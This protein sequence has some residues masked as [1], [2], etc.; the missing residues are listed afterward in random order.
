MSRTGRAESEGR[1]A[2]LDRIPEPGR[3]FDR[4]E[5]APDVGLTPPPPPPPDGLSWPTRERTAT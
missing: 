1:E 2:E 5:E 4:R 3:A